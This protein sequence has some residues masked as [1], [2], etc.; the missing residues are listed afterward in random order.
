MEEKKTVF[1]YI[2]QTMAIY[3]IIVV[4][5][6]VYN[7]LIG[8][9]A[10]EHSSLFALGRAGLSTATLIQLLA[11]S[12]ILNFTRTLFLS[13]RWIKN[14]AIF[15]RFVLSITTIMIV[16]ITMVIIFKWFP[17][18]D[19]MAWIGFALS[20]IISMIISVWITRLKERMENEK[21]QEAL[22]RFNSREKEQ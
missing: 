5:F 9:S 19:P 22:N 17:I 13:D 16:I 20:F 2:I 7:Y 12:V 15:L 6:M 11:L 1:D 4:I 8:D 3:G 14:M 21:M 18:D 10:A